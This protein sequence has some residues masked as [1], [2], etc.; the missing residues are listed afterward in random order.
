[1]SKFV[2]DTDTL[3]YVANAL[4]ALSQDFAQ[5]TSTTNGLTPQELG[6]QSVLSHL[7]HFDDSWVYGRN[8]IDEEISGM[9]RR[10]ITAKSVYELI[11]QKVQ[12]GARGRIDLGRWGV[13]HVGSG[14]TRRL[15]KLSGMTITR[16]A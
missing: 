5:I 12:Q 7:E 9:S 8:V 3:Q 11:E 6:G 15:R 4:G 14:A 2:V 10:L 13:A 16:A 1:M